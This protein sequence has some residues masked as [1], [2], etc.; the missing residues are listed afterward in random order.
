MFASQQFTRK[1]VTYSLKLENEK[2]KR[3]SFS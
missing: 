1:T 2:I 3:L